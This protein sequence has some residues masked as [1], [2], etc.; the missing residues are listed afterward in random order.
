MNRNYT[1][2]IVSCISSLTK[3][4]YT[5]TQFG[6]RT[7]EEWTCTL[8]FNFCFLASSWGNCS[9]VSYSSLVTKLRYKL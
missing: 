1:T 2:E 6:D 3:V 7:G 4:S 5:W 9:P 8:C